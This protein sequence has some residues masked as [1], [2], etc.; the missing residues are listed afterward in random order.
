VLTDFGTDARRLALCHMDKRPDV[1]LHQELA[2]AGAL[3]E[4]DTFF[5]PKYE[6]ERNVWP[7][8]ERMVADGYAASIAFGTDLADIASWREPGPAGLPRILAPRL[9]ALGYAPD[10]VAALTGKNILARLAGASQMI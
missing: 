2:Q 10:V 8:V 7:L 3:L 6:P 4:Y 5:R 9:A 1:G